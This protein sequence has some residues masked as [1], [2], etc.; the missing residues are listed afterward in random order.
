[1]DRPRP[2]ADLLEAVSSFYDV[3]LNLC[4]QRGDRFRTSWRE[5]IELAGYR[6]DDQAGTTVSRYA[7]LL[8]EVGLVEIGPTWMGRTWA[9]EVRLTT[10]RIPCRGPAPV[11]QL[12]R[13]T[14]NRRRRGSCGP[15]AVT[16]RVC[17]RADKWAGG[18]R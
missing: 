4:S 18:S 13:P 11:A 1:M 2:R 3:L 17:V 14:G 7:C 16:T 5:L 15:L 9:L 6:D 8:R 12:V 10:P